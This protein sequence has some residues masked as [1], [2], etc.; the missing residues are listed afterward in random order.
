[1]LNNAQRSA[2][3]GVK[4]CWFQPLEKTVQFSGVLLSARPINQYLE[5]RILDSSSSS[6]P[7]I[8]VKRSKQSSNGSVEQPEEPILSESITA[9]PPLSDRQERR[10]GHQTI[11]T[12]TY[13]RAERRSSFGYARDEADDWLVSGMD[14][15]GGLTDGDV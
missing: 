3:G 8:R 14:T 6:K 4:N 2:R 11:S 7:G 15:E 12:A 1:M 13:Y 9:T 5:A 10:K